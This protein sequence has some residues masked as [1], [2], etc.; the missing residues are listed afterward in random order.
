MIFF[1]VGSLR[2]AVGEYVE[3]YNAE[4][5]HQGLDNAIPEP[6]DEESRAAGEV[7]ERARLGGLLRYYHCAA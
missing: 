5:S 3:H 4:R 6:G 7:V 2:R 1:G